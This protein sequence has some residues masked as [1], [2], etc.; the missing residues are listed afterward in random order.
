[1]ENSPNDIARNSFETVE[2]FLRTC[3]ISHWSEDDKTE[4]AARLLLDCLPQPRRVRLM[5][6]ML[7]RTLKTGE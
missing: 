1:M 2:G 5:R 6:R 3:Q 7:D 4:L